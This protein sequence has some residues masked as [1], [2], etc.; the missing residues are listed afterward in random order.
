MRFSAFA[1]FGHLRFSSRPTH[2]QRIYGDM[3]RQLGGG[4][5]YSEGFDSLAMARVYANAMAF[6]RGLYTLERAGNQYRPDRALEILPALERDFGLIPDPGDRLGERRRALAAA[7][8]IA[9]GARRSNVESVLRDVLGEHFIAYITTDAEDAALST[10]DPAS[11]GVY[12]PPGTQ[13]SVFRLLD[14]V[15]MP[16][17]PNA[18]RYE[19]VAG[20]RPE[21]LAGDRV[22][23]DAGDYGRAEAVTIE[24]VEVSTDGASNL[25]ATFLH[26]HDRGT[27]IA[28]GRHPNQ[29]TSKRHNV[30][31]LSEE[32]IRVDRLRNK[33]NRVLR[34]LLRG[35]STWTLTC[36]DPGAPAVEY[37]SSDELVGAGTT[38]PVVTVSGAYAHL[39]GLRVEV[40][41]YIG[42]LDP[43]LPVGVDQLEVRVSLDGGATWSAPHQGAPYNLTWA[44]EIPGAPGA[45]LHFPSGV[46]FDTDNTYAPATDTAPMAPAAGTTGPFR[47]GIGRLGV[48]TLGALEVPS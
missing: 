34:R 14:P 48:T 33:A 38:P 29:T 44:L 15:L 10:E 30:I 9:R 2:G 47:V 13:R 18:V 41:D 21:L 5:N 17:A 11:V 45:F 26:P 42:P 1:P 25:T 40:T 22:I 31:V 24:G 20:A 16:G 23:V 8:R 12:A 35:V 19:S 32:A 36:A 46:T 28:T 37:V 6:A 3:A 7:M 27:V 43:P 39:V 4:E